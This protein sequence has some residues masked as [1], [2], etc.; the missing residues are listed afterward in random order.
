MAGGRDIQHEPADLALKLA[1]KDAMRAAGGQ[2]FLSETLGKSQSRFSDYGSSTTADF[3]PVN[4]IRKVQALGAGKP[5]WPHITT[6]LAREDGFEL[7]KVPEAAPVAG[8]WLNHISAL[9]A[10]SS[11]ITTKICSALADDQQVCAND[12]RKFALIGDAEQLLS[13]AVQLLAGL[14]AVAE[15]E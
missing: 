2:E 1:T 10:E 8:D 9:S 7:F 13:I 4:D 3:M 14:R 12:I 6:A 15:G 11:E 5:G